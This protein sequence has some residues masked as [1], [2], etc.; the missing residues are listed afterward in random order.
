MFITI[1]EKKKQMWQNKNLKEN[2]PKIYCDFL[3]V[4]LQGIVILF[5]VIPCIFHG[6]PQ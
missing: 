4:G 5:F 1:N 3:K 2:T 6:F